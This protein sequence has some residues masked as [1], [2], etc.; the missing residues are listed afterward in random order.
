MQVPVTMHKAEKYAVDP[1][2]LTDGI[3]SFFLQ[4]MGCSRKIYNL[5]TDVYYEA[6]EKAGYT[7][8]DNIPE[9]R[10]P[11]VT[12]FKEEYPFLKDADSLGLANAKLDFQSAV[13]RYRNQYDH[14]SYTARALRRDESGTEKLSFRGLKGMPKFHAKAHG[15]FS[16][17]TNCQYP[18]EG[19]SLKRPTIRLEQDMLYLPKL[20]CGVR[21]IIHR[22]LPPEAM[23][24]NVTVSMDTDGR[25]FASV[26]YSYILKMDMDLRMAALS[27]DASI[28]DKLSMI[29]LDYSQPDFY[30]DS[31][32][33]KANYPHYYRKSEE[34]LARLQ[35]QLSRMKKDSSNYRKKL[36]EIQRLHTKIRNQ[37]LDFV[38]KEAAWLSSAYDVVAV[39][40]IDLRS[41]GQALSLGKNLHDNGFG[42]F[43][44][45][46][47]RK[48]EA[49]GSVLVKV[50]RWYASTKTCSCC[51]TK[52]QD[53]KLGVSR[54]T[55]PSCG[56]EHARDINAAVNIREEGR[57]IF[58]D[59]FADWIKEDDAARERAA[60]LQMARRK[61]KSA[62]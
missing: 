58:L 21:L 40:D 53:V 7:S 61:K 20:K 48:L 8:G 24:G 52:N 35:R 29:G 45:I 31:E 38:R 10:L 51:G 4:N 1:K 57:R 13:K 3:R 28:L 23:I 46:L 11:E 55:C 39:E 50:D 37:R 22:S 36:A 44:D 56:A 43:R 2:G 12:A 60:S 27:G 47:A 9:I 42:L 14:K 17:K 41:M 6:L 54:W 59:Y 19:K 15:Y 32:G 18:A 62:A 5:Y 34:N 33:R 49:K 16:Y 26:E 30:V 25:F